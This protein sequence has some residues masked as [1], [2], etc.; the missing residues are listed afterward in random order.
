ML[1]KNL[2]GKRVI[3]DYFCLIYFV[4]TGQSLF[5]KV[6][7]YCKSSFLLTKSEQSKM[8]SVHLADIAVIHE[9]SC[10]IV[11]ANQSTAAME[12]VGNLIGSKT[13]NAVVPK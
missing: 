1:I 4:Q 11:Y 12:G 3:S 2:H 5:W 6:F 9:F 7:S 10:Q 13:E 8:R